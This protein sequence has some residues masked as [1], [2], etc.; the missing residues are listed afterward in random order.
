MDEPD[1]TSH[2]KL[3]TPAFATLVVTQMAF[4]Y[5]M[6]TFALLPKFLSTT[7]GASA[8]QIGR[9]S[10][11]QGFV[12]VLLTPF[13]G[14]WLDRAGRQPL[15]G[16]GALLCSLYAAAWTTIDAVSPA[17]YA[18]QVVS[19]FGFILTFN[20]ASTLVTENAPPERLGQAIGL[21]G[22]ANISMNAIAPTIAEPLAAAY[23][24]RAAFGLASA[25]AMLAFVL[26]R[27]IVESLR[28][29]RITSPRISRVHEARDDFAGTAHVARR[30]APYLGSMVTCGAAYG[31]ICT[32]YQPFVI[33][34]GAKQVSGFFVGFTVAT[35]SMRLLLGGVADRFGR[36][37]IALATFTGYA[38]I[39][40]AMTQITPGRLLAFGMLF[41]SAHGLYYPA[42][43]ALAIERTQ[44]EERSRVMTLI[45][46]AFHGGF[47]LS[48]LCC[49]W[50]AEQA[51]YRA[52]FV[53]ASC[54]AWLGVLMLW[55]DGSRSSLRPLADRSEV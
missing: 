36:R 3:L 50:V 38:L 31:A 16:L 13:V 8:S 54:V 27:R 25:S 34:Q 35:V 37:R 46:G 1:Q 40:L 39:A 41:G 21:F 48:V 43:N 53:V 15:I 4:S 22:A 18:L 55:F 45:N 23:G 19:A 10:A 12:I 32:F 14:G 30:I 11:V 5:A 6:S 47:M 42:L 51:G 9:T 49:G 24:W 2:A 29:S 44:P 28:P 26:S 17:S 7:L 33:A 20:A 52:V